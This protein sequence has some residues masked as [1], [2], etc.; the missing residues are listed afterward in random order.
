[1]KAFCDYTWPG[2]VRELQNVIQQ[3]AVLS[4]TPTIEPSDLP[5][6]V[7][8]SVEPAND[9]SFSQAKAQMIA[10]FEK[11][12][13]EQVLRSNHG[14]I[15]RAARVAR[16]DRRTFARLVKKHRLGRFPVT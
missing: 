8:A 1:M 13:L 7:S 12:Y 6:E 15:S 4:D 3:L 10:Q 9:V 5:F 2:N 11:A 14:N 16:T